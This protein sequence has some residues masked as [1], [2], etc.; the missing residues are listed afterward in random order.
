M[1]RMCLVDGK[2][3]RGEQRIQVKGEEKKG[4]NR[5]TCTDTHARDCI[6]KQIWKRRSD[7]VCVWSRCALYLSEGS[8]GHDRVELFWRDFPVL[9]SVCSFNH[10][11]QLCE[12]GRAHV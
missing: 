4:G 10:L 6:W 12:I 5:T 8:L 11:Q 7:G 9:I 1:V 2:L 3:N